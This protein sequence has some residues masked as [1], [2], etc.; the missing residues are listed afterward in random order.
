MK[1]SNSLSL[2]QNSSLLYNKFV[3]NLYIVSELKNLS[4][5]RSDGFTIKSF[6]FGTVKLMRKTV[7]SDFI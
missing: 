2:Q 1:F 6:L 7:K 4:R 3:L 5:N